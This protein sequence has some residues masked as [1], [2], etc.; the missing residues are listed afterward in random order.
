[1]PVQLL[2]QS[3]L[4]LKKK[5]S[6]VFL[7]YTDLSMLCLTYNSLFFIYFFFTAWQRT[8]QKFRLKHRKWRSPHGPEARTHTHCYEYEISF[9]CSVTSAITC[10]ALTPILWKSVCVISGLLLHLQT[11]GQV[12]GAVPKKEKCRVRR[13]RQM[14][15]HRPRR[16]P[17]KLKRR[18]SQVHSAAART[19]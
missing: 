7:N 16:P 13:T 19:R 11:R 9:M 2:N 4:F 5:L 3:L 17:A 15:T 8:K 14:A 10:P 1:M 18:R 6:L 12:S